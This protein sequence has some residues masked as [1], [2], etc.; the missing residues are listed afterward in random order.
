M[1]SKNIFFL[2]VIIISFVLYF[3]NKE[4]E[5]ALIINKSIK[6]VAAP[7]DNLKE[8][9]NHE[10]EV[11]SIKENDDKSLKNKAFYTSSIS[12][13]SYENELLNYLSKFSGKET[14]NEVEFLRIV[15]KYEQSQDYNDEFLLEICKNDDYSLEVF[16]ILAS[17]IISKENF[18]FYQLSYFFD[19]NNSIKRHLLI[20]FIL[21]ENISESASLN[22]LIDSMLYSSF[23]DDKVEHGDIVD[24]YIKNNPNKDP[25]LF[26]SDIINNPESKDFVKKSIL[27]NIIDSEREYFPSELSKSIIESIK[28]RDM[29]DDYLIYKAKNNYSLSSKKEDF[30]RDV[31]QSIDNGWSSEN[32]DKYQRWVSASLQLD[33]DNSSD[34]ILENFRKDPYL[35][36]YMVVQL[37]TD[38]IDFLLEEKSLSSIKEELVKAYLSESDNENYFLYKNAILRLKEPLPV[39]PLDGSPPLSKIH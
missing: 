14:F 33:I 2:F 28:N 37:E 35:S 25:G 19:G 20:D 39:H 15:D 30:I 11:T 36:A 24:I 9:S 38:D 10:I 22:A 16:E 23:S 18:N 4:D 5:K 3:G 34:I 1:S 26:I 6:H 29:I 32:I 8:T 31:F 12:G 27:E 21:N 17:R 13:V 7:Q